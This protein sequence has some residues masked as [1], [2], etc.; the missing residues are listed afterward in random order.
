M[1]IGLLTFHTSANYGAAL[2]AFALQ[3]FLEEQGY[4]TEYLDYL[5]HCRRMFYDIPYHVRQCIK[6]GKIVEA[7]F[8]MLGMPLLNSRKRKFEEFR[9]KFLHVSATTWHTPEEL[10]VTNQLYDKFIAGSDQIWNHKH[11]GS[12]TSF[13]LSFVTDPERTIS[14]A[15]SFGL[16]EV[17]EELVDGYANSLKRI[18]Y[19]STREQSG[20]ELIRKLTGR[21]ALLTLDPVFL[22]NQD[23]W[24]KQIENIPLHENYIFSYTNQRHQMRNFI[25]TTGYDL[26]EMKHHKLSRF[27]TLYDFL[28][29][30]VKVIYDMAPLEFLANI[31]GAQLVVSASFHCISFAIILNRPFVCFL[32]GNEGRDER[33]KTL[34]SHFGLTNRI[35]SKQMT[36]EDVNRPI[37]WEKVNSIIEEKRKDSVAFLFNALR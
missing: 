18:K 10:I 31:R 4:E 15:S 30:S 37:D 7:L 14:Y 32:T 24:T 8:Y 27:T 17:P 1:K 20:V 21:E 16:A 11:N 5:N 9:R 35:F 26:K 36:K 25:A 12:D 3:H 19:L 29:P 28:S 33:L 34:L 13:M 2:Q 22:P 23:F 6:Q